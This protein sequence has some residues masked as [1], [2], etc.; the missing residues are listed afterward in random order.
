VIRSSVTALSWLC[1]SSYH[2]SVISLS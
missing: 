1:H 2:I